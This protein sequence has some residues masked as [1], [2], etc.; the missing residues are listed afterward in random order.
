MLQ[1]FKGALHLEAGIIVAVADCSPPSDPEAFSFPLSFTVQKRVEGSAAACS[2]YA[3]AVAAVI[4]VYCFIA[5]MP[6][7][8]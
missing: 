2:T 4:A 7:L 5:V 8:G 1:N 6:R 3:S